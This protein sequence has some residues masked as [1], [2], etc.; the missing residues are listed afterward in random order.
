MHILIFI[1]HN[2][3]ITLEKELFILVNKA[4]ASGKWT[5]LWTVIRCGPKVLGA[6]TEWIIAISTGHHFSYVQDGMIQIQ[7]GTIIFSSQ[8]NY[9]LE[10]TVSPVPCGKK[11]STSSHCIP[12]NPGRKLSLFCHWFSEMWVIMT[13]ILWI[14]MEV[15]PKYT[16]PP[17]SPLSIKLLL[18]TDICG[19]WFIT[20][21][22]GV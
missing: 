21:S 16:P 13:G 20:C 9:V 3:C 10:Y 12:L 6:A 14:G 19:L 5:A 7:E 18:N 4:T 8:W 22:F 2:V 11:T 17:I 1:W 15:M